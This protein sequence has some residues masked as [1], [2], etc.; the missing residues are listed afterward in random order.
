MPEHKRESAGHQ[1]DDVVLVHIGCGDQIGKSWLNF[2]MT[3]MQYVERMPG[4]KLIQKLIGGSEYSVP[5]EVRFGDISKGPLVAPGTA[6]AA[7]ASHVLE[8]LTLHD[9]RSAIR[10]IYT[11]LA[12]GGIFRLIVPDLQW[13]AQLYLEQVAAGDSEASSKFLRSAILGQEA[14]RGF[15]KGIRVLFSGSMHR[16]MWDFVSM[17]AALEEAGFENVRRCEYGDSPQ[18]YFAEVE[19][20]SRFVADPPQHQKELAIECSKPL[21]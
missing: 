1:G 18:G 12:P 17:K 3:P 21:A 7:Y 5:R 13:R 8:H 19:N 9:A 11:L 2:D 16:W 10:N 20:P 15:V 14:P 6:Q 4:G